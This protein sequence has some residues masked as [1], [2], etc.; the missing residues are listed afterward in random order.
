MSNK[1]K[2]F[3]NIYMLWK[4]L[5]MSCYHISAACAARAFQI[6]P[7][8]GLV[9]PK[10]QGANKSIMPWLGLYTCHRWL[11]HQC[12]T[13]T[14]CLTC[15]ITL[16]CCKLHVS[17][18]Y[19]GCSSSWSS[20]SWVVLFTQTC[21]CALYVLCTKYHY[22]CETVG[23]VHTWVGQKLVNSNILRVFTIG[24]QHIFSL[25]RCMTKIKYY[26][27]NLLI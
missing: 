6:F 27:V 4:Y 8:S 21:V 7:I 13:H 18:P 25:K 26:L 20:L 14:S 11:P 12:Q 3:H 22:M 5:W 1:Y 19:Y 24:H 17:L 2:V 15:L 9:L 10:R 16:L 23:V